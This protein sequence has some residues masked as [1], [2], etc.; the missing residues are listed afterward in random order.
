MTNKWF[1]RL[2]LDNTVTSYLATKAG[3]LLGPSTVT[4]GKA[5]I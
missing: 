5:S 4:T 2:T 3:L 1:M